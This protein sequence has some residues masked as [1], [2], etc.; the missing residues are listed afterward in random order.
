MNSDG[1]P[2]LLGVLITF[3]RPEQLS[4]TLRALASQMRPLDHLVVVDNDAS[5]EV[6]EIIRRRYP[7]GEAV[8][9]VPAPENLGCAGGNA[10]GME[11]VLGFAEDRD[12]I[13][14][15]DD[16]D[17]PF[18]PSLLGDLK[19]FGEAMLT[20]DPRTAAVGLVGARF[21][22]ARA[23]LDAM[24]R[25]AHGQ[26]GD[27]VAVDAIGGG[28]FPLY[29]AG[30]VR[31]VAPYPSEYFFGFEDLDFGLRLRE[32]GYSLYADASI[33]REAKKTDLRFDLD[34]RPSFRLPDLTWRRYYEL[35]NIIYL[36]RSFHRT[37]TAV[38]VSLVRG[39]GKPLANL[40]VDPGASLRHLRMNLLACRDAWTGRMG[41]TIDPD[42]GLP[43]LTPSKEQ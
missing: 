29:L 12:W 14:L 31:S 34:S 3:R 17:P 7:N 38:R 1:V 25:I 30:A 8:E 6:E 5:R 19:R 20:R 23:R 36:L 24:T 42:I 22:W 35:R 13:V 16:D 39:F 37:G 26:E 41:R 11:R 18:S 9:Y 2:K 32:A 28:Q 4:S 27:A 33:W 43:D 15:M 21:D 40:L 10:L